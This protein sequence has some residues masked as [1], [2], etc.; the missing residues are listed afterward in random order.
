LRVEADVLLPVEPAEVWQRLVAW[1]RQP[2]W[3]RDADRVRVVTRHREGNGVRIAVKTRVLRLP[4]FTEVLEV[5]EWEPL[6]RVR[7]AH[8][9]FVRGA[10]EWRLQEEGPGTRFWW[11]EELRLPVRVLGELA[12]L[13]YRP[14]MRRL[15]RGSLANLRQWVTR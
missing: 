12:L 6:R 4:L 9:G 2:E 11:S 13:A 14:L 8:R 5:T 3:M 15:M 1:E 10:G 7:L